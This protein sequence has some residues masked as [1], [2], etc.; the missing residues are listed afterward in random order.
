MEISPLSDSDETLVAAARS[1]LEDAHEPGRHRCAAALE[2]ADGSIH[3]GI[4]LIHDG[5][6][7][8][9]AEPIALGGAVGDGVTEITASVAIVY[10]EDDS[11]RP[12]EVVAP[13]GSCRDLLWSFCGECRIIVPTP[14]GAG[15]TQLSALRPASPR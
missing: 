6:P 13:C 4:N 11:S 12:M 1:L 14:S 15:V 3:T 2:A 7:S 10:A 8:V 5:V 9:H